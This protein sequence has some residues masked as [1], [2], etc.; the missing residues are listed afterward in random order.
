[1][2]G[3]GDASPHSGHLEVLC[4][5]PRWLPALR[6]ERWPWLK[7]LPSEYFMGF[8]G[9]RARALL[10]GSALVYRKKNKPRESLA[11]GRHAAAG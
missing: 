9:L 1:M 3:A 5:W 4:P 11:R 7:A 6:A 8:H 2:V 10:S